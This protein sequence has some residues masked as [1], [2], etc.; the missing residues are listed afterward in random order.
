MTSWFQHCRDCLKKVLQQLSIVFVVGLAVPVRK[1]ELYSIKLVASKVFGELCGIS[2]ES[3]SMAEFLNALRVFLRVS[4][5]CTRQGVRAQDCEQ[6][7]KPLKQILK[8]SSLTT[9]H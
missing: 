5:H 1:V 4:I 9:Y 7:C 6:V 8:N 2:L 3:N